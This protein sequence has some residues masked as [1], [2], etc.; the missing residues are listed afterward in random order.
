VKK[1]QK[2]IDICKY[3][4]YNKK[5]LRNGEYIL[6]EGCACEAMLHQF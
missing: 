2:S 1:I 3:I 4:M 5:E 6:K